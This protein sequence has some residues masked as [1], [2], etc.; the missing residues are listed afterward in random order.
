MDHKPAPSNYYNNEIWQDSPLTTDDRERFRDAI[1]TLVLD[2]TEE[3]DLADFDHDAIQN[4]HFTKFTGDD[5]LSIS[6]YIDNKAFETQPTAHTLYDKNYDYV[7]NHSCDYL[8]D[9]GHTWT[10]LEYDVISELVLLL[11]LPE[12]T[13]ELIPYVCFSDQESPNLTA[14]EGNEHFTLFYINTEIPQITQTIYETA[15]FD[16]ANKFGIPIEK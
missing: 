3:I 7:Y 15:N 10:A 13:D 9:L 4:I 16:L 6:L 11:D 12:Y 2:I 1:R 14:L 8:R 5:T